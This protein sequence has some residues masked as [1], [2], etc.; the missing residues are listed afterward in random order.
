MPWFNYE[1]IN[2]GIEFKGCISTKLIF[3]KYMYV[4]YVRVHLGGIALQSVE[5][6][7]IYWIAIYFNSYK[8]VQQYASEM[9]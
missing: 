2:G 9:D 1:E 6:E 4:L 8:A 3:C 7:I 5:V